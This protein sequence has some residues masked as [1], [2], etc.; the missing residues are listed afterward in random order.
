MR[1]KPLLL[2]ILLVTLNRPLSAAMVPTETLWSIGTADD[3]AAE[4]ALAPDGYRDFLQRDFGWE[5]RFFLVGQAPAA[6]AWPYVLPGPADDWAGSGGLAGTRTQVLTVLFDLASA[7][8]NG[9]GTLVIDLVDA[10]PTNPPLLKVTVNGRPTKFELARGASEASLTGAWARGREQQI[11]LA[12]E[13]GSLRPGANAIQLTTIRGSWLV[14]DHL[15]LESPTGT[16][17]AAP[18]PVFVRQV[19]AAPYELEHEGKRAQPLLVDLECLEPASELSVVLDGERIFSIV[20]EMGRS[21]LEVPMPAV[22][23]DVHPGGLGVPGRYAVYLGDRLLA[24]GTVLRSSHARATPA[25]Y[26]DPMMGSAHS[27]WMIAP[28]PWMPFSMVKLSPNNQNAG[29]QAGY[30]PHLENIGG[31][32][33]IHEWTM[34][35]L[36]MMPTTG[37]LQVEVGDQYQPDAGYRSRADTTREEARIGYYRTFLT[38]TGIDVELTATTRAGFQ[39]YTFPETTQ[40]RVLLDFQFPAEYRFDLVSVEVRQSS[41]TR[42]E[43]SVEHHAPD[44]WGRDAQQEYVLHFVAEFD[45]PIHASGVWTDAGVQPDTRVLRTGQ[46]KDAGVYVE[47]DTRGARTVQARTAISLVSLDNADLN[48]QHEISQPFGWNFAAIVDHQ[49]ATWNELLGR[50]QIETPDR[51]E[52][53]RFYTNLYRSFCRNIWSDVDGRWRDPEERI[54]KL[55]D[56]D[57]VMLGCDAFWNTFW[58]L[59]QV[60]NLISPEWSSR[61]VRSQL[62]LYD[63]C[64]WLAKG[65]AGL[66]YIP[67]MVAEHEIPLIVGAYQM[68]IRDFDTAK[69]LEAIVK[70]QTTPGRP[71]AGGYA[72]NR[73]LEAYL[74]HRYVPA[75]RGRISNTLEYAF[76]DW[77]VAQLARALGQ[78]D[79]ARAFTERSGYWR[80]I[81]DAE[82]GFARL[83][84]ADGQWVSPFDPFRSGANEHYVEGNAWQLTFFVPQDVP[85]LIDALGRERFLARLEDGF[86]R[87]AATRF[88]APNELYWDYPVVHGNQQSMHFAFLFNWAG[89]PWLTQHWS[90]EVLQR[91]YGYGTGDAYLGDEDQGQMSAWF[92]MAALGLFQMDG[93]CRVD[94]IYEIGSPLYPKIVIDLGERFG[95]G[96]T[97][98][99]TARN[100]SRANRYVQQA[101]LN[102]QPLDT[103]WFRSRDL[104]QGGELLLDMGPEPNHAWGSGANLP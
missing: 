92:V 102:G 85:G 58:N 6:T 40:A 48:L 28:G 55:T 91:Y 90:R 45:R 7:G 8:G 104:L 14:F 25:D 9:E 29:W 76:D 36:L 2:L 81:F 61:W 33:H 65:P 57:A 82:T 70:M 12:L 22:S 32:S 80:N 51:R 79:L 34:A 87:S 103:W 78:N 3:A 49:R 83:R 64:G 59:N 35:G 66:E 60:W 4:F 26:V 13:P 1:T 56:P 43:G 50:I 98:T 63:A 97:F 46:V 96:K 15:R 52:K 16:R 69:A 93:G 30:D 54:Q 38:D 99:I 94:P 62:A 89:A 31:F 74:E 68:G 67:V 77:T 11:A 21:V 24:A 23:R 17:L 39:R 19:T 20:P 100:V 95:R 71:V 84:N 73:D 37:P 27:R 41:A 86:Q 75:D 10:H 44:V 53:V 72:G 18:A 5:N 88:N 101:A 42:I 47:F